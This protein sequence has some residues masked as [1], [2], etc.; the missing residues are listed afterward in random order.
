MTSIFVRRFNCWITYILKSYAHNDVIKYY[1][2]LL[3]AR[4]TFFLNGNE[5]ILMIIIKQLEGVGFHLALTLHFESIGEIAHDFI[6]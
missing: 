5:I 6:F 4:R 2:V 3:V 1:E